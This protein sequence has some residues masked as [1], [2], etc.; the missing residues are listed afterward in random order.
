MK[1]INTKPGISGILTGAQALEFVK[2]HYYITNCLETLQAKLSEHTDKALLDEEEEGDI[3]EAL[4]VSGYE[5]L[6]INTTYANIIKG[7]GLANGVIQKHL[8][9]GMM[10]A[11][12]IK[13]KISTILAVYEVSVSDINSIVK[14]ADTALSYLAF[15][16]NREFDIFDK[17][18]IYT[19]VYNAASEL[20]V[21]DLK[22]KFAEIEMTHPPILTLLEN[23]PDIY[24][25]LIGLVDQYIYSELCEAIEKEEISVKELCDILDGKLSFEVWKSTH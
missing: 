23:F 19:A 1:M 17:E 8:S 3:L 24:Q 20:K 16:F 10:M 2:S 5:R 15:G 22:E 9:N 11:Y 7:T 12:T 4:E 14:M 6:D 21:K 25:R 13:Q 18:N